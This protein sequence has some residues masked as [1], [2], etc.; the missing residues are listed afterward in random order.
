VNASSVVLRRQVVPVQRFVGLT[1]RQELPEEAA[2]GEQLYSKRSDD[3]REGNGR[4]NQEVASLHVSQDTARTLPRR[5][6]AKAAHRP[7]RPVP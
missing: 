1:C 3:G 5:A 4:P 2:I 6:E 7:Q